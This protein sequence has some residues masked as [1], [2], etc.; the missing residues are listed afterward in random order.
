MIRAVLDTNLLI[1]YLLTHHPPIA[2]LL[3]HHLAGDDFALVTASELLVGLDDLLALVQV[4]G[5][6]SSR[7]QSFWG[8]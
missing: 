6:P 4:G 1:S 8:C 5:I 3:D 2:T 7:Q